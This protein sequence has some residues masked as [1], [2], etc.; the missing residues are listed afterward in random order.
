[1]LSIEES[2]N[3]MIIGHYK[4]IRLHIYSQKSYPTDIISVK[5]IASHHNDLETNQNGQRT[6][7]HAAQQNQVLHNPFFDAVT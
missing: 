3:K 7:T 1:M 4:K 6:S 2:T 5:I